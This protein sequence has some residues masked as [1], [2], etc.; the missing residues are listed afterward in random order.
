MIRYI[1]SL[2][3]LTSVSISASAQGKPSEMPSKAP[4]DVAMKKS[5]Q[6][7]A[8]G[9]EEYDEDYLYGNSK[10]RLK[11]VSERSFANHTHAMLYFPKDNHGMHHFF[12]KI[13]GLLTKHKERINILHIGGSH[14]QDGTLPNTIRT[15]IF[16]AWDEMS[17]HRLGTS[18]RGMIF[19]FSAIKSGN[20][21]SYSVS[22]SG[23]WSGSRNVSRQLD[24]E[25]GLMGAAA[26]TSDPEA[27]LTINL[28]EGIYACNRIRIVGSA[29]SPD[30]HPVIVC[31]GNTITPDH[32]DRKMGY[33]FSLPKLTTS[34]TIR[35]AGLDDGTFTLRGIMPETDR[36]GIS[37]TA[38][39]VIGASVPSWLKCVKFEEEL[40]LLPPDLVI[41]GI[42]INDADLS[43][44]DFNPETF[45]D[46]YRKLLKK[47]QRI[48]PRC[49]F[50]FI[51]NN[52]CYHNRRP[53]QNTPR[54]EKAFIELAL[55]YNGAVF[56]VFQIMGGIGSSDKWYREG[57]M[58]PDH[59][60][61]TRKGYTFIGDL[62]SNAIIKAFN[63]YNSE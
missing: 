2:L 46:N 17:G 54:V 44:G 51:T 1:L 21:S 14:V 9:L 6:P 22:V 50:I 5:V 45:K 28:K 19:P 47:I 8:D 37:Y 23:T 7:F 52:D 33:L 40:A 38:S 48:N 43:V 4:A 53:N 18:E 42:G 34:F 13:N 60:H 10:L 61:F 58:E 29:S 24:A 55:E 56:N 12:N 26:M 41:F 20:P 15:N 63:E 49:S 30:V 59:V 39:G 32:S 27:S 11:V 36:P 25:L 57:Y 35:F 62:L 16:N 31:D 3:L